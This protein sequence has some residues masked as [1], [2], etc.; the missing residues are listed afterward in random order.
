MSAKTAMYGTVSKTLI[1]TLAELPM[2]DAAVVEGLMPTGILDCKE[3]S[4]GTGV[5]VVERCLGEGREVSGLLGVRVS[6]TTGRLVSGILGADV[7]GMLGAEVED[8][9][10]EGVAGAYLA[11][12]ANDGLSVGVGPVG[13]TGLGAGAACEIGCGAG[14]STF[15]V[16]T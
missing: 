11:T 5:G 1:G 3:P 16:H 2:S 9:M 8:M 7:S 14:V 15:V 13:T 10:G 12:G 4:T 6:G